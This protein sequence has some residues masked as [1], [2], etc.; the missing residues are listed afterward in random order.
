MFA[1]VCFT[2]FLLAL[3]EGAE[4]IRSG[5]K[6]IEKLVNQCVQK[7]DIFKCLKIQ[8]IKVANRAVNLKN[9]SIFDGV[10][11]VSDDRETKSFKLGLNLND[12]KLE[13]LDSEQLDDLLTDTSSR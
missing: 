12:T 1:S 5:Y 9:F 10:S 7:D 11:F 3:V 2:L 4:E 6:V 8:A 13:K